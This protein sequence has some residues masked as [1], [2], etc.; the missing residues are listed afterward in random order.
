MPSRV[1]RRFDYRA[2]DK[3]LDIEFVSG[4]V[5]R[6]LDVPEP[7]YRDMCRSFSKGEFFNTH[8]RDCFAFEQIS[9]PK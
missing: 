4:R 3:A 8:I 7:V 9:A 6:Y 5:Y 2:A 1:I